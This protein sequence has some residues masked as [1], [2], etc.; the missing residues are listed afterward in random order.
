[1]VSPACFRKGLFTVGALDNLDHNPSS[2]TSLTSFHGTGISLF[3]MPTKTEPGKSRPSI[4]IPPSGKE[5]HSF[6]DSY[7][8]VP[9]VAFKT[10]DVAVPECDV[11]PL[12]RCLDHARTGQRCW[13]EHALQR[14]Q[15]EKLTSG[16]AIAWAA[17]HASML[18][19]M[20]DSPALC[21]LLPLFYEKAA[22]PAMIK[23][24]M[25]IVRQAVHFRNPGQDPSHYI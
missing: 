3:Q 22:T 13:L 10:T 17:Y 4:I 21:A 16:D 25:D 1:M 2:T 23:H 7:A 11:F 24:G 12:Q 19:P 9:A 15:T 6:P 8:S 14:L 18:P 20:E 5:K